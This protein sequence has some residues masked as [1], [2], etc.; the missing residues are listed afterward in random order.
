MAKLDAF[1]MEPLY[2]QLGSTNEMLRQVSKTLRA[3]VDKAQPCMQ[4]R[5]SMEYYA[6]LEGDAAQKNA[7]L[8]QTLAELSARVRITALTLTNLQLDGTEPLLAEVVRAQSN[9][10]VR[11]D[12]SNNDFS[13]HM[14][15]VLGPALA[16]CTGLT[17][18]TMCRCSLYKDEVAA[19]M[20]HLATCTRLTALDLTD[21]F[22]MEIGG[23]AV[24][25]A[26]RSLPLLAELRLV[27]TVLNDECARALA[28]ALPGLPAL[29]VLD[30]H[31]NGIRSAGCTAVADALRLC[32]ALEELHLRN[33]L[34]KDEGCAALMHALAERPA[35][36]MLVDVRGNGISPAVMV[37]AQA[38]G[39]VC[40]D[41][42]RV[43]TAQPLYRTLPVTAWG[44]NGVTDAL[45]ADEPGLCKAEL[46]AMRSLLLLPVD[47]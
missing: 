42:A 20:P 35:P 10:L 44:A 2:D 18:V 1:F 16:E 27:G 23:Q 43:N 28:A 15:D 39:L 3:A 12:F 9:H 34:I 4:V 31:N 29:R 32:P 30:L 37:S 45:C 11:V 19:L 6:T 36:R 13:S 14:P 25:A 17:H 24:A 7:S 41:W 46:R 5:V 40:Y 33:N 47:L 8:L 38:Q 22:L 21:N 26:L